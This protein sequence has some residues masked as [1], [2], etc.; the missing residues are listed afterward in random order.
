[1]AAATLDA[2][3]DHGKV[4]Y[5]LEENV[6]N[7]RR[8]LDE[9]EKAASRSML[10]RRTRQGRRQ[11]FGD[12]ADKLYGA[13]A[14]KRATVLGGGIDAQ[15]LALATASKNPSRKA[16]KSGAPRPKSAG[17]G[18]RTNRFGP[19]MTKTNGSAGSNSPPPPISPTTRIL[20]GA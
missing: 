4:R 13:V 18:T 8:V 5:S 19:A 15:K 2:F 10:S 6:D 16:P 20:R 14:H 3:R 9:L 12:S 7:A 17:S 1:V 11:L